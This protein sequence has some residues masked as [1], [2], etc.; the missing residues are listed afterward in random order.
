ML[1]AYNE[2]TRTKSD[3]VPG[4]FIVNFEHILYLFLVFPLLILNK[5]MSTTSLSYMI[6]RKDTLCKVTLAICETRKMCAYAT[7]VTIA[8]IITFV[9]H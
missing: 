3:V 1:K 8:S 6:I 2:N 9:F 5:L 7:S 4:V